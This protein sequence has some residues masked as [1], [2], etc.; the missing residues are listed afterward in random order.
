MSEISKV[1]SDIFFKKFGFKFFLVI[2][3]IS[4]TNKWQGEDVRTRKKVATIKVLPI[5][6][7]ALNVKSNNIKRL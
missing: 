4:S 5:E 7:G 1:E 2:L 6:D 3:D